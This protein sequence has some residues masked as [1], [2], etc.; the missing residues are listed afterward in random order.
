MFSKEDLLGFGLINGP[1]SPALYIVGIGVN[2]LTG[3]YAFRL[4]GRV[5]PSETRT[6][7]A[8]REAHEARSVMLWPVPSRFSYGEIGKAE[9][10]KAVAAPT[11]LQD[12]LGNS[13]G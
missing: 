8:A 13:G 7:T 4:Y 2:V 10:R 3:L 5:F 12:V 9:V 6:P 1:G 11:A